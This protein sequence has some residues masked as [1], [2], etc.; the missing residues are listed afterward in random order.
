MLTIF[1]KTYWGVDLVIIVTYSIE[2]LRLLTKSFTFYSKVAEMLIRNST[3]LNIDLNARDLEGRT[4][5]HLACGQEHSE[6]ADVIIKSSEE[7]NIELNAQ[8]KDGWTPFHFVCV[9]GQSKIAEML[10]CKYNSENST[11]DKLNV[12]NKNG[13]TGFHLACFEGHRDL[14]ELLL[15]HHVC[16]S[17]HHIKHGHAIRVDE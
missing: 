4:A 17:E 8:D 16:C 15:K 1:Q 12:P 10:L 6:L 5:F 7:T 2:R 11:L 14:A 13:D 3:D 9:Y